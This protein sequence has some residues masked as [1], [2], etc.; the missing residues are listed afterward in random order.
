MI[1]SHFIPYKQVIIR[2]INSCITTEQLQC[3][4]DMVGHFKEVFKFHDI[5]NKDEVYDEI[6]NHYLQKQ[7]ELHIF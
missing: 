6:A 5:P 3:C 4:F 7:S 1:A 2:S